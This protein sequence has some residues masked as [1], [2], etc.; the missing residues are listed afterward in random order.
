MQ[1]GENRWIGISAP[2]LP[3]L[4]TPQLTIT[5]LKGGRA[6][7]GFTVGAKV[8]PMAT[9]IGYLIGFNDRV[10]KRLTLGFGID[11]EGGG[12]SGGEDGKGTDRDDGRGIDFEE[13]VR[14]AEGDL[15]IEVDVRVRR[16]AGG[17]DRG[18]DRPHHHLPPRP[19][20][21]RYERLLRAG[22][23]LL[24]DCLAALGSSDPFGIA[25]AI[26]AIEAAAAGDLVTLTAAHGSVLERFDAYMTMLQKAMGDRA[27]ILQ[28][29]LA[30]RPW[31]RSAAPEALP[32]TPAVQRR[33]LH[34]RR[35]GATARWRITVRSDAA[36][37]DHPSGYGA[38]SFA[39]VGPPICHRWPAGAGAAE[40]P[41]R[42]AAGPS[43]GRLSTP[44]EW[45][46]N[47]EEGTRWTG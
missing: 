41:S 40:G 10:M 29:A 33:I 8:S 31:D 18:R 24:G 30:P 27:D 13:R 34:H 12:L 25:A 2:N 44:Q 45:K 6:V 38:G 1:P 37:S 42:P 23:T 21:Q 9:V 5:E 36:D 39:K 22:V 11:T 17:R 28:M 46:A 26:A 7:N 16:G 3:M 35:S 20:P 4:G 43:A 15:L 19:D 32:S 14:L 47:R